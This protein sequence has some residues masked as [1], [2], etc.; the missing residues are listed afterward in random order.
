[1]LSCMP[2]KE[3]KKYLSFQQKASPGEVSDALH[4]VLKWQTEV[5]RKDSTVGIQKHQKACIPVRGSTGEVPVENE[6][7]VSVIA[8]PEAV[9][10]HLSKNQLAKIKATQSTLKVGNL[11]ETQR[12][13]KAS[14]CTYRDCEIYNIC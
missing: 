8:L 13:K 1:M 4:D 12:L 10:L 6:G 14:K 3:K 5:R 7:S 11:S 9:G 2:P